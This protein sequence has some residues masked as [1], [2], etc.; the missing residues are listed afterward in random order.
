MYYAYLTI[1]NIIFVRK[2]QD[3]FHKGKKNGPQDVTTC[4]WPANIMSKITR[5]DLSQEI[6]SLQPYAIQFL[7]VR[8]NE[9]VYFL[10]NSFNN[11]PYNVN[12]ILSAIF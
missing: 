1:C 3:D 6:T 12:C 9:N 2:L 11:S 8:V 5:E 7:W 10:N 4:S